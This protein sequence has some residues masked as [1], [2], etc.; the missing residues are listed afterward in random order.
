MIVARLKSSNILVKLSMRNVL[1]HSIVQLPSPLP[2]PVPPPRPHPVFGVLSLSVLFV[3]RMIRED[4][5][6]ATYTLPIA[7]TELVA[8]SLL[9]Q[10]GHACRW[11]SGFIKGSSKF[12]LD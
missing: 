8:T 2:Y 10:R 5:R 12:S 4:N 9:L 11:S 3:S 1:A 7:Q 6:S